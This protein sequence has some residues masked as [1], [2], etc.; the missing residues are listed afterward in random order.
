MVKVDAALLQR[1]AE[2]FR[3]QCLQLDRIADQVSGVRQSLKSCGNVFW[4]LDG[5]ALKQLNALRERVVELRVFYE[6]L[7]DASTLYSRCE[8]ELCQ[9]GGRAASPFLLSG[10]LDRQTGNVSQE[11]WR[12]AFG[13]LIRPLLND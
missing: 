11:E 10:S 3:Q 7:E 2:Q 9:V 12:S 5:Y 13:E 1:S 4:E 8:K 6:T